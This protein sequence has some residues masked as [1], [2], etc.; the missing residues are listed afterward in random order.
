M[1]PKEIEVILARHLASC[2]AL[3]IFIL[4]VTAKTLAI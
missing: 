1:F 4:S 3:P 2:L